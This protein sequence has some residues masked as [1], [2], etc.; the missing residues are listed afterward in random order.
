MAGGDEA[1][2]TVNVVSTNMLGV[3]L[4][5]TLSQTSVGHEKRVVLA[6]VVSFVHLMPDISKGKS[7]C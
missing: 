3:L 7:G 2:I 1:T 5:P 6:F 4:S